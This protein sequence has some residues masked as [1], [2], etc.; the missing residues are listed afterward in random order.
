MVFAHGLYERVIGSLKMYGFSI[1]IR[2]LLYRH[3][4]TLSSA[5]TLLDIFSI[6][7]PIGEDRE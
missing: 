2:M 6:R 1:Y 7:N 4:N 5:E 3:I